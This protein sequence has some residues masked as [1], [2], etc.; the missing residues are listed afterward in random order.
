MIHPRLRHAAVCDE[1][2]AGVTYCIEGELVPVLR[3]TLDRTPIFFD[4]H[5]LL[6]KNASTRIG[7]KTGR[8]FLRRAMGRMPLLL[9]TA[10]GPG[11]IALSRD[12]TGQIVP[13]HLQPGQA[14][15]TRKHQYLAATHRVA[16]GIRR[17]KGVRNWIMGDNALFMDRFAAEGEPGI[18]WLHGYGNVFE[19]TLADQEALDVE[20]GAWLYKDVSVTM[21][22]IVQ[23]LS[24]GLLASPTSFFWNRLTGPGRV[25]LQSLRVPAGTG[26]T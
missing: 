21:T 14:V 25:G 19:V 6:W 23:N 18:V 2:F 7:A 24:A 10:T 3:V 26:G 13:I 5:I 11:E 1:Q 4:H 16:Y 8:G 12:G 20:P 22:T 9:C 15:E 17:V